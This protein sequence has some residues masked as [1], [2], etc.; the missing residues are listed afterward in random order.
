[1]VL[2]AGCSNSRLRRTPAA[3]Q[4]TPWFCQMDETRDDWE[5][6]QDADLAQHPQPDRLPSDPA[7]DSEPVPVI[8]PT[9]SFETDTVPATAEPPPPA[10]SVLSG[11]AAAAATVP[12]GT[13]AGVT[14]PLA[15][16]PTADTAAPAAEPSVEPMDLMSLPGEMYAVQLIAVANEPLAQDF[17]RDHEVADAMTLMLARDGDLYYVV[18]LGIY[19][20]FSAA[21]SAIDH[22]PPALAGIEPWIRPLSSIQRGMREARGLVTASE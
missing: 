21:Q 9:V 22:R 5:C 10:D 20:T 13:T 17:V 2:A 7:P 11:A 19:D 12:A 8:E 1:M 6:V 4:N 18:L 16:T 14:A 15:A 3:A